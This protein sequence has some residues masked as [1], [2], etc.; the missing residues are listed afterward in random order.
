[1]PGQYVKMEEEEESL[2][3]EVKTEFDNVCAESMYADDPQFR[4]WLEIVAF[5]DFTNAAGDYDYHIKEGDSEHAKWYK[6]SIQK[7]DHGPFSKLWT[8]VK[9]MAEIS[10][11]QGGRPRSETSESCPII[12]EYYHTYDRE[13]ERWDSDED[14]QNF[15]SFV[16]IH[17]I[18]H[19]PLAIQKYKEKG[20]I[21]W[22]TNNVL[23]DLMYAE[24]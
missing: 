19:I 2:W 18:D 21:M 1:M 15:N 4:E 22:E 11:S 16:L 20:G 6:K 3:E 12:F 23:T 9:N 10:F 24:V 5:W 7:E 13:N 8:Y 17:T 14:E